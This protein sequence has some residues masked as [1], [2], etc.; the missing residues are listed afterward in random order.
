MSYEP[1]EYWEARLSSSFS[2]SGA[3]W[4]GL[5]EQFLVWQYRAKRRAIRHAGLQSQG[6]DILDVGPGTGYWV[7]YW[8]STGAANVTAIDISETSVR[9]LTRSF[10][11]VK[12][13]LGDITQQIPHGGP[14]HIVSA[15]DV[16][17]HITE[18]AAYARALSN[19]RAAAAPGAK[20]VMIDPIAIRNRLTGGSYYSRVR[21][22]GEVADALA[23]AGWRLVSLRPALWLM[24]DPVDSASRLGSLLLR[25]QW[26]AIRTGARYRLLAYLIGAG[27][28]V[29]ERLL[30]RLAWGPTSKIVLAEASP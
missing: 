3:G 24:N 16:L 4:A 22:G 9:E 26:K 12:V 19:L 14:F 30:T 5:A 15:I 8:Q 21:T 13:E 29:P 10:P 20:L 18:E 6:L 27:A 1:R 2:L 25:A 7:A 28:S 17:L 23:A 11:A